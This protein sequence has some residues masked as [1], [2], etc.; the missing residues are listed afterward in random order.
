MNV[1]QVMEVPPT[2]LY[3]FFLEFCKGCLFG[4][5]LCGDSFEVPQTRC[6]IGLP[7]CQYWD[8]SHR[9]QQSLIGQGYRQQ[10]FP[11]AKIHKNGLHAING[12]SNLINAHVDDQWWSWLDDVPWY[13]KHKFHPRKRTNHC[14]RLR[15]SAAWYAFSPQGEQSVGFG[16]WRWKVFKG[17]DMFFVNDFHVCY[18]I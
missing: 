9:V 16:D 5:L 11:F 17:L 6:R 8:R 7:S 13:H 2:K 12:T 3:T 10:A 1:D 15:K 18:V 4:C 14:T